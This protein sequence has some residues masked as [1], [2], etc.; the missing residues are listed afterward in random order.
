MTNNSLE[1]GKILVPDQDAAKLLKRTLIQSADSASTRRNRQHFWNK[2]KEW[3]E[4]HGAI[5]LP[6]DPD[7]V[8]FYLLNQAG[9]EQKKST[10]NNMRWAIDTTHQQHALKTPTDDTEV[11]QKIISLFRTMAEYRPEQFTQSKK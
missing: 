7:T 11:K 9:Q 8:V 5:S 10:L 3:C 6:A 2:F 4:A 1:I